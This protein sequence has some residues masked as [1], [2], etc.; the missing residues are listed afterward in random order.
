[1]N[2]RQKIRLIVANFSVRERV[3]FIG[4][5]AL[6]AV[7]VFG[8]IVSLWYRPSTV[9][10]LRGGTYRE[11]IVGSPRF[12]NPVLAASDADR[13]L[14][15]LIYSGLARI[16]ESGTPIPD[17]AESWVI[18]PDGKTYTITLKRNLTFHDHKDLTSADVAFTIAQVQNPALKSAQR[19]AWEGVTVT[20]PDDRT[21][22]F[23]LQKPYAGF[24]DQLTLGILPEH[25]WKSVPTDTWTTNIYNTEPIGSGPFKLKNLSRSRIGV[26]EEYTLK[27]FKKFALSRPFIARVTIT[28]FA[29]ESDAAQAFD[30]GELDGLAMVNPFDVDHAKRAHTN[31]MT[32][33]LPRV[34]GL[35]MNPVKNKLFSE[36]AIVRAINLGI[37]RNDIIESI[38][39]GYASPLA[40]PLPQSIDSSTSDFQEKQTLAK[41]LLDDA[42][43]KVNAT[44]GVREKTITSGKGKVT[45]SLA[46]SITT[47]NT[48]ELEQAAH[49][50]A[51]Q[52]EAIGMAVDVK[53]FEIGSLNEH[54]IRERDFDTLLFGQVIRHDTDIFAFWHSSQ[55]I[56]PGLNITGYTNKSVDTWLEA[57]IKESDA[58]KRA[59]LYEKITQ[60]LAKD[61]PVAFLY[62]PDFI[63]LLSPYVYQ[64]TVPPITGPESRFS[65]IWKWYMRTDHVWNLFIKK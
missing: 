45:Q 61:A 3:V 50:V 16:D 27:A 58:Q 14:S 63:Y 57:A 56:N 23:N 10:P 39:K 5:L 62:T 22:V 65:L 60:Q 38:F 11:G 54:A 40:G 4:A 52:L 42:G 34:F 44:T 31:V 15:S 9:V 29:N 49:L 7:G 51:D 21:I 17:L 43:W 19:V 41:K 12:I 8:G 53:V 35:F 64:P 26:P 24:L 48:P 13:D 37:D 36:S 1:M 33:P 46:F 2:F 30:R 55:K 6:L 47:A 25:I 20:T 59:A 18:S 32:E 28:S